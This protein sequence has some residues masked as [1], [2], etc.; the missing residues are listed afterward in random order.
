MDVL[1]RLTRRDKWALGAGGGALYAPPFPRWL[2]TP[3]FWDEC[4]LADL[5]LPR[6]FTILFMREGRP[7]RTQGAVLDWNPSR[8]RLRHEGDGLVV[9]ETRCVT[10][11]NAF[12]SRLTLVQGKGVEAF[13]WSLLDLREEGPGAPW[14]SVT[15][16]SV[17]EHAMV[18]R[19]ETA[20][21]REVAP[22]RTGVE[23]ENARGGR[24]M[25]PAVSL[26]L[27]F[28]AD[29]PRLSHTVNLAQ[30][31]D[32]SPL[33]ELSVLPDKLRSGRLPGDFKLKVGPP[34]VEG[35]VHLVGGYRLDDRPL[36]FA[37]GAGLT[38]AAARKALAFDDD[39]EQDWKAYFASVP[40]FESDD[41]F[42]TGA[43]WNRWFGL[44]LNTIDL[45]G[46]RL[47]TED[48]VQ[49]AGPF[50]AEG[51][52]FFRNFVTYSAQAHLREVAWMRDPRLATG[53]LDNLALVQREDGSFPGHSYSARPPRDFYHA[54]F[55]TPI[56]QLFALH[57]EAVDRPHLAALR[58][59]ADYLARH[60][61]ASRDLAGPTLY[62]VFDQ[63]ETGQEYMSRYAF[64]SDRAD[65]WASFRVSGV[66]ATVYAERTFAALSAFRPG[67]SPYAA[68]AEGARRGL[69]ERA[70]DD[71]AAFFC[72]V[73]QERSRAR[74][75]TGLYPLLV[76]GL[77]AQGHR[78]VERWLANP[79]EFW[80]E[81]GFP[82]TAFSDPTFSAEGEWR[83]RRTNCPWNGRSWPMAN[84]H[85]VDGLSRLAR[86]TGDE[87]LRCLAGEALMKAVRLMFHDGDPARP[88]SFEHYDPQTGRAALYR[89]Y[90][91]YMH[92]WIVDLILRHACGIVPGSNE[93]DP[94]PLGVDVAVDL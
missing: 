36:A 71:E 77:E 8:L 34:P 41:P 46:Y 23:A 4:H 18:V 44:R 28:G 79:D 78:A 27:A 15:D 7:V 42:L 72:D 1:E 29:A 63:N 21:P 54:D 88:N 76:P 61:T 91:D 5:R 94:L 81:A 33:F 13:L 43:Y 56:R 9:E 47:Q 83:G 17:D 65:E 22:D 11:G 19:W 40:Q 50:V 84:A 64:A 67:G 14:A 6:L 90:D 55:G 66:D 32:E 37:C 12:V 73:L 85:L 59:Y 30:R 74:P 68:Y 62:D 93:R 58:R 25:L 82:A 49:D 26:W 92:S 38:E 48:G 75:A 31:H 2:T 87:D 39:V 80:L 51:P 10:A 53:I 16:V 35:L 89:G 24:E 20:W 70:W 3:G 52:G 86:A 60:R 69:A 45:P 57:P